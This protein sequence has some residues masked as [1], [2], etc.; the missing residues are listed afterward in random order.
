VITRLAG[1][2]RKAGR[3][4][5]DLLLPP[6]CLTCDAAVEAPGMFCADCFK[7]TGFITAPCCETCGTAFAK[8]TPSGHMCATCRADPP[9]W[10]RA[11]AALRYDAQGRR[12]VLPLKYNDRTDLAAALAPLMLRAGGALVREAEV[13]VPVPLHRTRL[14]SRRFNQAALIAAH[15]ARQAGRPVVLDG[16]VRSRRTAAL[17]ELSALA[18][19]AM[20]HGAITVRDR[21]QAALQGRRV[22][23][24]DDVLT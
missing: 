2:V 6:L 23:L 16:L 19:Q 1:G 8:A 14:I 7:A 18:R 11:R 13:I 12:V 22:L 5:L 3:A 15:L 24:I 20:L 17:A 4:A 10:E 21:R 9:P